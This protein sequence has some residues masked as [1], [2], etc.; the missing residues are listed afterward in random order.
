METMEYKRRLKSLIDD[1]QTLDLV[2]NC[3]IIFNINEDNRKEIFHDF[4][5]NHNW[6]SFKPDTHEIGQNQYD[7]VLLTD[8][9]I[10]TKE[11]Y[12]ILKHHSK[13]KLKL[14]NDAFIDK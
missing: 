10:R 4:I 6:D 12:N 8:S 3:L 14:D 1:I 5:L 9:D 11:F 2:T 7:Y 13:K